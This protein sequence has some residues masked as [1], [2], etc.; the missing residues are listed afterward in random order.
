MNHRMGL[1]AYDSYHFSSLDITGTR[2][3]ELI[4]LKDKSMGSTLA[5][6]IKGWHDKLYDSA[7]GAIHKG[8]G[9]KSSYRSDEVDEK[10]PETFRDL[11]RDISK[12]E[13]AQ[14]WH[15]FC[16]KL[17]APSDEDCTNWIAQNNSQRPKESRP[18]VKHVY[19]SNGSTIEDHQDFILGSVKKLLQGPELVTTWPAR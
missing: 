13:S 9:A 12:R 3:R 15:N 7:T 1:D 4:G 2:F 8:Y 11:V 17:T 19:S 10:I 6:D 16:N 14:R 5:K 18:T